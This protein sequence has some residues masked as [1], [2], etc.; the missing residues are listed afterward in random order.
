MSTCHSIGSNPLEYAAEVAYIVA[1]SPPPSK[2]EDGE[3]RSEEDEFAFSFSDTQLRRRAREQ[4]DEQQQ[5]QEQIE[6][7]EDKEKKEGVGGMAGKEEREA[8][9][10]K[11]RE[12]PS[13]AV[14]DDSAAVRKISST[15]SDSST[16]ER[17]FVRLPEGEGAQKTLVIYGR[18]NYPSGQL[19]SRLVQSNPSIFTRVVPHTT[20]K[21]RGSELHGVDFHFVDKRLMSAEIKKGNF[22]ECV[23]ISS[24]KLNL[25]KTPS[26][27]PESS[28]TSNPAS[29]S[30]EAS[31]VHQWK[32]DLVQVPS[33]LIAP[34]STRERSK[35]SGKGS[36]LCGTSREAIHRARMN[37]KPCIVVSVTCKG[38]Q[39]LRKAG[40][41]AVYILL[42]VGGEGTEE[43]DSADDS[44]NVQPDHHIAAENI[45]QAFLDLQRFAFQSVSSLPLSPRTK[46]DVTRDEWESLPTVQ[47][48]PLPSQA[49]SPVSKSR[50][51]TFTDLLVHYQRERIGIKPTKSKKTATSL[52]KNLRAEHDLVE[53]LTHVPLSDT[54][55]LHI[56]ALQTIYQKLMGSSLNCRRYGPHWQDVGFHGVDPGEGLKETGFFGIMQLVSFL[57]HS[58][59][60]AMEIFTYSRE[61]THQFPFAVVSVSL[62]EAALKSLSDG[63]L[64]KLCNKQEQV[65]VTLN[66]YH[67]AL[68]YRFYRLWRSQSSPSQIPPVITEAAKQARKHPKSAIADVIAYL[69]SGK[70]EHELAPVRKIGHS[71]SNPF[72]PFPRLANEQGQ[73]PPTSTP[74]S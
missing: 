46:V 4:Q 11:R 38:A 34:K 23:K 30:A 48:D 64:V 69:Q 15:S 42:D 39:Q 35:S 62:T 26:I 59:Q 50:M 20:R 9:E 21:Q 73:P 29:P 1:T 71:L 22:L 24:P 36:V 14:E 68:F 8:G 37:G 13:E 54:D 31:M 70:D 67:T 32:R 27:T 6:K 55:T 56:E 60:L 3:S 5:Q 33:P 40:C 65:I 12:I 43:T 16:T 10:E 72:T 28:D 17:Q 63:H 53:S 2:E 19:V 58:M 7:D 61:G 66:D 41:E 74:A 52:S 44:D 47:M 57:E 51:I 18:T 49:S 25:K 45:D